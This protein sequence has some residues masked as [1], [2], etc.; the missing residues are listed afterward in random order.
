MSWRWSFVL[1]ISDHPLASLTWVSKSLCRFGK[2]SAIISLNKLSVPFYFATPSG[3]PITHILFLLRIFHSSYKHFFILSLSFFFSIIWQDNFKGPLFYFTDY[4]F[5]LIQSVFND[6][7]CRFYFSH[8][9]FSSSIFVWFFI[10]ISISLLILFLCTVFLISLHCFCFLVAH[11][12]LKKKK[13]L[14]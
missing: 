4:F 14:Y 8:V 10:M 9:I 1:K 2:F 5:C 7:Y 6:L 13:Q 3:T 11:W 12:T